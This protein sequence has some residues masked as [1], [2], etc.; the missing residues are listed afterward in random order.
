M[1]EN[2]I[3]ITG[4]SSGLG[5]A[6]AEEALH[7][8]W[9]VV[10]TVRSEEAVAKFEATKP[11]HAFGRILDV[12]DTVR[13]ADLVAEVEANV[14]AI[15]VLV[16]NAG[17]GLWSTIEEAPLDEIRQQFEVNV[18]GCIAMLQAVLPYMRK[19]R[20]GR[21]LN[22]TSMGGLVTFPMVGIYNATKFAMEAVTEVLSQEVKSFGI[23]V[24]AVEPGVFKTDWFG[25]SQR[26]APATIRDYDALRKGRNEQPMP[27]SGDL[28]KGAKAI[29]TI[30][31]DPNPP[32]HALLG[33]IADEY[34]GKKLE[35][36]HQEFTAGKELSASTNADKA[37]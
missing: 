37:V 11:G 13:M 4:V 10:G 16:N 25:R 36:L 1:K 23:L 27:F 30:L 35:T 21:I 32:G 18:F 22:I 8:G 3:L 28:T 31:A 15:N 19:R 20:A 24:T 5:K 7:Q 12:R 14:G 2:T 33:S 17:Y 29:L 6:L 9:R 34:V 26:Q